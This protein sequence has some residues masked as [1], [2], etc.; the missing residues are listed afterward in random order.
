MSNVQ[1]GMDCVL[2]KCIIDKN[3]TIPDGTR[4]GLDPTE[5]ARRFHVTEAGV[6][7]VTRVML[8][9]EASLI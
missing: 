6:T 2:K 4:I 1:I 9:Q 5:D 8:G 7:L 3:C